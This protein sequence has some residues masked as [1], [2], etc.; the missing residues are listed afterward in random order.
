MVYFIGG[1]A[2]NIPRKIVRQ[3]TIFEKESN[4][5]DT[6]SFQVLRKF[7][8]VGIAVQTGLFD[9]LKNVP[10]TSQTTYQGS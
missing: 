9:E 2:P 1:A 8:I 7:L 4:M 5:P 3:T 6:A 10:C